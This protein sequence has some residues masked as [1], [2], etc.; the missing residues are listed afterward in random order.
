MNTTK[1]IKIVSSREE[2]EDI[3]N[4]GDTVE[5]MLNQSKRTMVYGGVVNRI[6]HSFLKLSEDK[7]SM[8]CWMSEIQWLKYEDGVVVFDTSKR[9]VDMIPYGTR[10]YQ[11]KEKIIG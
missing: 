9:I 11:E 5:V 10:E 3:I 6:Y 2:L 1:I 4:I 8:I 7:K